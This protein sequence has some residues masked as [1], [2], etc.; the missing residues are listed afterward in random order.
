MYQHLGMRAEGEQELRDLAEKKPI[1]REIYTV[2]RRLAKKFDRGGQALTEEASGGA[3][4]YWEFALMTYDCLYNISCSSPGDPENCDLAQLAMARIYI[5]QDKLGKAERVYQ[6]ILKRNSLSADAVYNLGN[7]YEKKKDWEKALDTWRTFS[8]GVQ[9]GTYHWFEA[10]YKTAF[11]LNKLGDVTKACDVLNITLVL[12][13]D[14]G[15]DEM[16]SKYQTLRKNICKEELP[17]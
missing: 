1:N 13:P 15:S 9:T 16:K 8:D 17:L 6:D 11:A 3:D 2:L 4:R 12:H 5:D 10:R 7:L 14:L